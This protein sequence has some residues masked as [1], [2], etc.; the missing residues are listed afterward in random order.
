MDKRGATFFLEFVIALVIGLIIVVIVA[1]IYLFGA[2]GLS[3]AISSINSYVSLTQTALTTHLSVLT[4]DVL[5]SFKGNSFMGQFYGSSNC[6]NLL[7]ELSRNA[8]LTSPNNPASLSGKF[9]ICSGT[10]KPFEF[11]YSSSSYASTWDY[12]NPS[13]EN[14]LPNWM[15]SSTP[16]L[17]FLTDIAQVN[18][19]RGAMTFINNS[20]LGNN[21]NDLLAIETDLGQAC[22]AF[23]NATVS[24]Y[25]DYGIPSDY[26]TNLDCVPLDVE[27][28]Q[29]IFISVNS[30]FCQ[31]NGLSC[32]YNPF[33]FLH[34]SPGNILEQRCN[35]GS[36]DPSIS[37]VEYI[38]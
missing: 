1:Y 15:V 14:D 22:V 35:Y 30:L 16:S 37:C 6:I 11:V 13:A 4:G 28:G 29:P 31:I 25:K 2:G 8:V 24:P 32:N 21:Q 20:L 27:S 23:L 26:I 38:G 33:L 9:F 12:I 34:G 3:A 10:Y 17:P 18:G 7:D 5:P 36:G 19:S